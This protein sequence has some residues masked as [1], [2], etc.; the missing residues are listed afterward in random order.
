MANRGAGGIPVDGYTGF[1]LGRTISGSCLDRKRTRR[2]DLAASSFAGRGLPPG[3]TFLDQLTGTILLCRDYL[4]DGVSE[5]EI[6]QA[7][8]GC[9]VLCVSDLRNLSSY[10]G[11]TALVTLVSLVS[12]MRVQVSV[13]IPE[14]SMIS[15]QPP[16][17]GSF[18]RRS[19]LASSER[20]I[21][22]ATIRASAHINAEMTFVLG[23][24]QVNDSHSRL[25]RLT[26][27]EWSGALASEGRAQAWTTRWPIGSMISAALAAGEVFKFVMRKLPVREEG[28]TLFEPS[29]CSEWDFGSIPAPIQG[30][31]LGE[32]DIISAG[33]IC[34]SALYALVRIPNVHMH[35]RIFDDDVTAPSNLNRN[36]LTLMIDVGLPKVKLVTER[37]GTNIR[38]EP[39]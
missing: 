25:S 30:I 2:R 17:S 27:T 20:L 11:Q 19:L 34:Q 18:L 26:G 9:Q 39:V 38:V 7:F 24:S 33:A 4:A 32:V 1:R 6:C 8:Q 15:P 12:R 22:G 16:F 31:D 23:D 21:T 5:D 35:G 14:V 36:M 37:C 10:S 13:D 29:I 3:M 28:K